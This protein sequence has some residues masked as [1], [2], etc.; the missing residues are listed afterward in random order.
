MVVTGRLALPRQAEGDTDE[1]ASVYL[2]DYMAEEW[3]WFSPEGPSS[4][5]SATYLVGD[6]VFCLGGIEGNTRGHDLW[7]FDLT[8][9][10]W[11]PVPH[12]NPRFLGTLGHSAVYV[13]QSE[14]VVV[15]GGIKRNF[16][17]YTRSLYV[18]S[19][20]GMSWTKPKFKG[21]W[22]IQDLKWIKQ[23]YIQIRYMR[24]KGS[25]YLRH[26]YVICI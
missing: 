21:E 23:Q 9:R 1:L 13:E 12:T 18:V 10:E 22:K 24:P 3:V 5:G 4:Y 11:S 2:I 7:T 26:E 16:R 17:S 14:M 25:D 20:D 19:P 15:F 6:K 8:L